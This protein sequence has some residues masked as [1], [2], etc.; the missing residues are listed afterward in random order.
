MDVLVTGGAGYIGSTV[1][2]ALADAGHRPVV[3]DDLSTGRAEFVRGRRFYRGDIADAGLVRRI[4]AEHPGLRTAVHCAAR[5]AVPE[6]VA[7]PA[8][9]YRTNVTGTLELAQ[10][11]AEAG[12]RDLVLSG[13]AA[14]YGP[15]GAAGVDEDAPWAPASPYA[16]TKA[17]AELMLADLAAATRLR[18]LS[19]RYFNPVGADPQLRTGPQQPRPG[20]VL[21]VLAESLRTGASFPVRGTDYPTRDGSALRDYVHVWDLARAH[22]AAVEGFDRALDGR[23]SQAINLGTGRGTTVHELVATFAAVTGRSVPVVAAPRRPGDTAGTFARTERAARL[24]G[25]HAERDLATG[26][27]DLLAWLERRPALLENPALVGSSR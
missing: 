1:A 10:T 18:V 13:S 21:G 2:S 7:R 14:V 3:L 9:Y 19:L 6:S 22:V 20:H 24:L 26:I 16:R 25:W 4:V 8:D 17:V 12:V 23:R 5:V 27:A 11:L 15:A